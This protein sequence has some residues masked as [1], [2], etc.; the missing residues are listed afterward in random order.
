[1]DHPFQSFSDCEWRGILIRFLYMLTILDITCPLI[2]DTVDVTKTDQFRVW[3]G[4]R[5]PKDYPG[6]PFQNHLKLFLWIIDHINKI[7]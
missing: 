4:E 6:L 5:D 7:S 1:M 2:P 3:L